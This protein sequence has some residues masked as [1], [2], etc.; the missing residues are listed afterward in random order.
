MIFAALCQILST[1]VRG[2]AGTNYLAGFNWPIGEKITYRLYWGFI[3]VGIATSWTEWTEHEGRRLLAIRMRTVSNKVVEKIYPVDDTIES[4]VD[5][6]TFLPVQFSKDMS[7]GTHKYKEV[8]VFDRSN[9]MAYWES[10]LTGKK[11]EYP[12]EAETRDI[13]SLMYYL[14]THT[15]VPGKREHFR[16]QAD[17]K[18]YDLW[19]NVLKKEKINTPTYDDTSTIKVEPEAAFNGLFVRKGRLWI[20]LSDDPRCLAVR[21]EA[22]I[23]VAN[24]RAAVIG[25]EGPGDDYWTKHS[26]PIANNG[27]KGHS[28]PISVI[29]AGSRFIAWP[30]LPALL[31]SCGQP[32]V[33]ALQK[34]YPLNANSRTPLS[35]LDE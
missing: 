26:K 19:V 4:L 18:V 22:S 2:E 21:I 24:I 1:T 31:K 10:K 6:A 33:A 5:P 29:F 28:S 34:T 16:V 17:E 20:W 13:P 32:Q 25:V 27:N 11:K 7:E 9:K 12:I 8:T 14:R 35:P 23:P 3:P 15:F 30:S